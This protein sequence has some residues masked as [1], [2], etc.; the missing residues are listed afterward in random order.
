V[1][2]A[3]EHYQAR[4]ARHPATPA[5]SSFSYLNLFIVVVTHACTFWTFTNWLKMQQPAADGA[6]RDEARANTYVDQ[7]FLGCVRE[8]PRAR[9]AGSSAA[10]VP[11]L[12][13]L[14][15]LKQKE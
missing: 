7:W 5:R 4:R 8:V 9:V 13:S 6:P 2:C 10:D 1:P 15:D 12:S 3:A 11:T 14:R